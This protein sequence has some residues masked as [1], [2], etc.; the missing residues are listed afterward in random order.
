M[1]N[2]SVYEKENILRPIFFKMYKEKIQQGVKHDLEFVVHNNSVFR[3]RRE[4]TNFEE[5]DMF[6]E[7]Q[8]K[9]EKL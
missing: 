2:R 6:R 7:V 9:D 3:S 4:S 5:D 8:S 1:A